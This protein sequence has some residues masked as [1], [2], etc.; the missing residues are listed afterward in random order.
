MQLFIRSINGKFITLN[1]SQYNSIQEIKELINFEN[2]GLEIEEKIL[3]EGNL[4]DYQITENSIIDLFEIDDGGKKKKRKKKSFVSKKRIPH[5]RK[6]EK[7]KVLKLF[8]INKDGSVE[9]QRK[10]C[11]HC[12]G[13]FLAKH[14]DGRLYCGSCHYTENKD[15]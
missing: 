1:V 3:T 4:E 11:P 8:K 10:P 9:N 13:A 7:L 5:T 12:P 15:K 6:K 14:K 2:C